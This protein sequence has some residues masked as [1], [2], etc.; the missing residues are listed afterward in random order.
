MLPRNATHSLGKC[1]AFDIYVQRIGAVR[2]WDPDRKKLRI[3]VR[4]NPFAYREDWKW[5]GGGAS[6]LSDGRHAWGPRV[7][8]RYID[9]PTHGADD[10]SRNPRRIKKNGVCPMAIVPRLATALCL[11]LATTL[12]AQGKITWAKDFHTALAKAKK[13][14]KLLVVCISMKG[15]RVCDVIL[16]EHYCDSKIIALSRHT[17]NLFCSPHGTAAQK[18]ME[19][20]VRIDLLKKSEKDWMV[21]PQHVI[22]SPDGKVIS[23]V[24][25]FLSVGELEWMWAEALRKH[26]SDFQWQYGE[27]VRAP[28]Q[29]KLE[30]VETAKEI[31]KPPT[32]KELDMILRAIKR[33]WG[34]YYGAQEKLP[35]IVRHPSLIARKFVE[36]ILKSLETSN[37]ER[38]TVLQMIGANSP[39]VWYRVVTPMLRRDEPLVRAAAARALRELGERKALKTLVARWRK[40]RSI[41]VRGELLRAMA[42]CGPTN[43]HVVKLLPIVLEKHAD[44]DVRVHAVVATAALENRKA[45]TTGLTTAL[46]DRAP[47]VRATAAYAIAARRDSSVLEALEKA[48]AK[49]QDKDVKVWMEAA[50]K[51]VAGG[52]MDAFQEF[53]KNVAKISK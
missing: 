41:H 14:N 16:V 47:R 28:G 20:R 10:V 50:G 24:S 30:K 36:R 11:C 15:E 1:L 25:Y 33:E 2:S 22:F 37:E 53:L 6:Y 5:P 44:E 8:I 52:S 39:R 35:V 43:V 45:V 38:I 27:R 4:R 26:D 29:L 46:A 17:V 31:L 21:A 7:T 40:E 18:E 23:S 48:A 42:V 12:P 51:V 9:E 13:E 19:R 32:K 34:G 3:S 49:E